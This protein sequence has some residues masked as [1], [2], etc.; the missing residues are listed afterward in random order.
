MSWLDPAVVMKAGG[1][2]EW[3]KEKGPE[4]VVLEYFIY[5]GLGPHAYAKQNELFERIQACSYELGSLATVCRNYA[6]KSDR[7]QQFH[8]KYLMGPVTIPFDEWNA[9][10]LLLE[11]ACVD[12]Q[13]FYWFAGRLLNHVAQT[14]S[15]FFRKVTPRVSSGQGV[16]SHSA[17]MGS[18]ILA[19][20]PSSLRDADVEHE[21]KYWRKRKAKVAMGHPGEETRVQITFPP[22]P[23]V[24]PEKPLRQ[25]WIELHDYVSEV[26]NF[27]GSQLT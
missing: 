17:L 27:L 4:H 21:V 2:V 12:I 26:S 20:L 23:G 22:E 1:K 24:H 14:L 3:L 16:S 10:H 13:T 11:E 6:S 25:L 18:S 7:V 9:H 8:E 5:C 19:F 15:Y